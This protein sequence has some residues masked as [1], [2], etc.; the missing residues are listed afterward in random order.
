MSWECCLGWWWHFC[1]L[2]TV[3]PPSHNVVQARVF[4]IQY[5][6]YVLNGK[7]IFFF[8]HLMTTKRQPRDKTIKQTRTSWIFSWWVNSWILLCISPFAIFSS[9][10][11]HDEV[12]TFQLTSLGWKTRAEWGRPLSGGSTGT[13]CRFNSLHIFLR[14]S[15]LV[16]NNEITIVTNGVL[17]LSSVLWDLRISRESHKYYLSG[18]FILLFFWSRNC[19]LVSRLF[20]SF[21]WALWI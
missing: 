3:L 11:E 15:L 9:G 5:V 10:L 4:E 13:F 7:R 12:R 19:V 8:R 1:P 18:A 21:S 2:S 14:K 6:H 17:V 16:S 20:L